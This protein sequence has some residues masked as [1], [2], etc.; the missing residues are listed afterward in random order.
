MLRLRKHSLVA[1]GYFFLIS[2]MGL[3]MRLFMVLPVP[4]DFQHFLHAHSH[5][6]MLGWVYLG[7]SLLLYKVFLSELTKPKLQRL[8]FWVSNVS[9][10]GMLISFP[11]QG[12]GLYSISFSCLYLFCTYWFTRF[13]VKNVPAELKH[14]LS[15]KLVRAALF[16]LVISSLGTWSVGPISAMS[17][18]GSFLFNDALYFFLHFLYSGFFFLSLIAVLIRFL[19][20]RNITFKSDLTDRFYVALNMGI[21]LSYF[22]SVLWTKPPALFYIVGIIGALYQIRGYQLFFQI[23]KP[24]RNLFLQKFGKYSYYLMMMAT[25]LLIIRIG[26]QL[27]SGIPYFAEVA[28][29]YRDFIIGYLHMVF[30]GIVSPMLLV[31]LA[32]HKMIYFHKTSFLFFLFAFFTTEALI[33]YHGLVFWLDAPI[34]S[35]YFEVL[36]GLTCLFPISLGWFLVVNI[37]KVKTLQG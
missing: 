13:V 23:L 20:K 9:F 33:F 29:N 11:I 36:A 18:T 25:C 8:I 31:F 1:L 2:I 24:Y 6:A 10:I 28:F 34:F 30:L 16:Y 5:V 37:R 19:E 7:L 22:L 32:Y 27:I 14:T 17:G 4:I 26:M 12:Y 15:W 21:V 3:L 35:N